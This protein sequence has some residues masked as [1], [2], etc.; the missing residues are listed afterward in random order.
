M[1]SETHVGIIV[2]V[3]AAALA[4]WGNAWLAR[5]NKRIDERVKF[6]VQAYVD[7]E[8]GHP[9]HHG[10]S[11]VEPYSEQELSEMYARFNRAV[12][13]INLMGSPEQVDLCRNCLKREDLDFTSLS[14]SLRDSLRKELGLARLSTDHFW[15]EMRP[16][17]KD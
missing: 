1:A 3:I 12:V 11:G 16:L 9:R 10:D 7:L 17:K 2:A 15:F 4:V 6:L 14:V 8:F 5:R 13:A